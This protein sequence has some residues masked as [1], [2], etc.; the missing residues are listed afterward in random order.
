[1]RLE[2]SK[3]RDACS[4]QLTPFEKLWGY[5]M[6]LDNYPATIF[7]FPLRTAETKS[8]LRTGKTNLKHET[9][10]VC[11]LMKSYFNEARISLLFLKRIQSIDFS[12]NGCSEPGWSI[13]RRPP[14]ERGS[15]LTSELVVCSFDK[16][17][18]STTH[19]SG[20][21][22]W[23]IAIVDPQT[24]NQIRES[25]RRVAKHAECGLAALLS[26]KSDAASVE[27]PEVIQSRIFNTLP[28]GI[29]S[30]LPVHVHATF[31]L[32]GDRKS[33]S[34][35]G[36]ENQFEGS[37]RNR[38]LLQDALPKLYLDFLEDLGKQA[39]QDAFKFWP[40][41]E[42]PK[43]SC[44]E[45]LCKSFWEQLP[46]SSK[47][48]FTKSQLTNKAPK[49]LVPPLIDFNQAVFDF[50]PNNSSEKLTRLLLS[51]GVDLVLHVP[52]EV[53][54]LLKALPGVQSVTGQLLR[55]LLK[56]DSSSR[57][58]LEEMAHDPLTWEV[59]CKNLVPADSELEELDG[60][61]VLP[62]ADGSLA[63]LRLQKSQDTQPQSYYVV[64]EI[65]LNVFNFAAGL[66]VSPGTG[67][68]LKEIL[69]SG[70]FNITKLRLCHVE[71]LLK[72]RPVEAT[73]SPEGDQWLTEFWKFWN[74]SHDPSPDIAGLQIYIFRA[75]VN[76][77]EVYATPADF[78]RLPS[79]VEP[80]DSEHEKLCNKIPG[81]Y[82]FDKKFMPESFTSSERSFES[83]VSF[84]R[85]VKAMQLLAKSKNKGI[86][87]FVRIHLDDPHVKVSSLSE[88]LAASNSNP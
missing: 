80:S 30:D 36:D 76:G 48:V 68:R 83:Q 42:P 6:S 54:K 7:R 50:L 10:Q 49:R 47:R 38:A 40:Q 62:L 2:L 12:I 28:L 84:R 65:E 69:E 15:G 44:A 52:I 17:M 77:V 64:S 9:A 51:L 45:L 75:T 57:H 31:S 22:S 19:I 35:D 14:T 72:M 21:D 74:A 13:V 27:I 29:S 4:D 43:R 34:I 32:S 70:K 24:R 3:L 39:I 60:C 86:E 78:S 63:P 85:L 33:I 87:S 55:Q 79:V 5:E 56:S 16:T 59:L 46:T 73:T 81:L 53:A 71:K 26:S 61:Y 67:E 18:E 20:T 8:L 1:M 66:L 82:R 25:S 23:C 58:L 37:E 11:Q 88:Y 41:Q